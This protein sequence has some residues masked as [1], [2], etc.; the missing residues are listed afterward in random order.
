MF[1]T[2]SILGLALTG[3]SS[4]A[5]LLGLFDTGGGSYSLGAFDSGNTS[6]VSSNPVTGIAAGETLNGLD[7]RPANSTVYAI[8]SMGN[9]YTLSLSGIATNIGSFA[10]PV[11]GSSYGFDFNP[12]FMSGTFARII[13]DLDDNRVISGEDGSYLGADKTDVFYDVGDANEGANPNINHIGYT[14]SILGSTATQQYGI[15][16]TL[17]VLVTVANNAG[18][19]ATVGSLGVDAGELGGFDIAGTTG[20]AFLGFQDGVDSELYSINLM[21][22]S[23]T[24]LGS[25]DGNLIGL[26]SIPEPSSALLLGLAGIGFLRR[27]R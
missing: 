24:S 3:A 18:T 27:R 14:N 8:G 22:G 13:S 1:Y 10:S 7:F 2:T 5:S 4:G 20:E 17:D 26:T 16:S 15:D 6:S 25:L 11:P 19:L 12:A 23:A 21:D 9:V